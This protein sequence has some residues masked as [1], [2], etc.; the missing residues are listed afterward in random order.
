ME[1]KTPPSYEIKSMPLSDL[2]EN[3]KNPRTISEAALRGLTASV[4]TFGP[5]QPIIWNRR[6][7]YIVGG[8]QRKKALEAAGYTEAQVVV[9]DYDEEKEMLANFSLN[10]PE[11][12]GEFTE[13]ASDILARYEAADPRTLEHLRLDELLDDLG[14]PE[15][16]AG[17]GTEPDDAPAAQAQPRV[18]AGDIWAMGEH[19]II[20]GDATKIETIRALFAGEQASCVFTDPP[21]GVS[22]EARSG[23]FEMIKND[24]LRDDALVKLLMPALKAAATFAQDDAA[25]YIWHA[26]STRED[27]VHA[28]KA[29]GLVERQYLIW[30]KNGISL[31]YSDYR[32]S[33]EPCFYASKADRKPAFYGDMGESTIWRVS[34]VKNDGLATT[35]GSGVLL[36]D[37]EGSHLYLTPGAPKAKKTRTIRL[38]EAGVRVASSDQA[39]SVWEVNRDRDTEHP[40]Q[41]PVELA[42]RALANS[43]RATEIVFDPFVGSGTTVIAAEMLGRRA[44]VM[45][46]DPVYADVT[47]RRWEA[48]TGRTAEK[49]GT[50]DI[51]QR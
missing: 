25:F 2:K 50:L 9:V 23:K 47:I 34:S 12:Q 30:A 11:I 46:L 48:F 31:G 14:R 16:E 28:M 44:R 5:I 27:F 7:G 21:Y 43:T 33:H 13:E 10:N 41:K 19:R 45:D 6:T 17:A 24:D 40:T 22:Y 32:W 51:A 29:A 26:S 3:P 37:G 39:G 4:K 35:L 49:I 8:H 42:R 38:T 1:T 18:K 36:T 15:P 20:C